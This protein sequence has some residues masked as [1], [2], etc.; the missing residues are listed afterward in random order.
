MRNWCAVLAIVLL[1]SC[2]DSDTGSA[3]PTMTV[4]SG[5]SI[6]AAINAAPANATIF[7]EPGVYHESP[8]APNAIVI[9]KD[10]IQVIGQSA[11]GRPVVLE[12]AGGQMNGVVVAPTDS[13]NVDPTE[14]HPGEHPPCGTNGNMLHSFSLKGFTVRGF[15]Q[16][17][18]YLACVDGFTLSQNSTDSDRLYG[19]FPVRSHNGTM[20]NNEATNTT[21]DAALYVG[22]SDHITI[23]GNSTHENLLGLEIENSSDITAKNNEV[24]DNTL[25]IIADVM[26]GLQKKDQANVLISDNNIHDNNH[27]N[28]ADQADT[29]Q[30]PPG[31]G[32]VILGG[33]MVTVQNNKVSNNGFAGI[34][35]ASFCTGTGAC[36]GTIDIDPNPGHNRIAN[37]DLNNNGKN[38]PA[39]PLEAALAADLV[40]DNTGTDN[41]WVGNTATA[42]AKT[43]SGRK[44]PVCL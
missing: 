36:G 31:T 40:W 38:P 33:T 18:V 25:G 17:G 28:M 15:D 7:V 34:I 22:Q 14:E 19:L 9:S 21:L 43:L 13:V 32:L 35:V 44:L 29:E 30:T 1:S 42:T 23:T 24:F 5:Q 12:N 4:H 41:C 26:P 27:P 2:G 8:S 11:P 10:G 16:F 6:Q 37:N 20:S 39:D 3:P